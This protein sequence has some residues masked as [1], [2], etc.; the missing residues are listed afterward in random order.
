MQYYVHGSMHK[1]APLYERAG[2][3]ST[4]IYTMRRASKS[5]LLHSQG[6]DYRQ[7]ERAPVELGSAGPTGCARG[8]HS[9]KVSYYLQNYMPNRFF[10]VADII[11]DI[12]SPICIHRAHLKHMFEA[13]V[14][15]CKNGEISVKPLGIL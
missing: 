7:A 12:V 3:V 2:T 4:S 1:T 11:I 9:R 15:R 5:F 10:K 6:Y 14:S 13:P 8:H